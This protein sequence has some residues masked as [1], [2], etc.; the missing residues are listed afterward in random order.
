MSSITKK[1]LFSLFVLSIYHLS[2]LAVLVNAKAIARDHEAHI[3][4]ISPSK[5]GPAEVF[6]V[7]VVNNL[8]NNMS[9]LLIHCASK[10]DDLGNHTL[11]VN[12]DFH[13]RSHMNFSVSTMFFCRFQ[14]DSKNVAHEVTSRAFSRCRKDGLVTTIKFLLLI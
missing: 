2:E 9:A 14:W 10:D 6:T 5:V 12:D 8:S 1:S 13:W 4:N 11:Y 3:A 7:H